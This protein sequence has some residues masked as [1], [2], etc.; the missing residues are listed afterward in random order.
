MYLTNF[1]DHVNNVEPSIK[2]IMETES[3]DS[4]PFLDGLAKRG[5][6]W[7]ICTSVYRKPTHTGGYL[8]N[9]SERPLQ[10][11]RSVVNTLLHGTEECF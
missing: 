11:K 4:I 8:S 7:Q 1:A 2:F 10:H 9:R 5:T 6:I 3:N